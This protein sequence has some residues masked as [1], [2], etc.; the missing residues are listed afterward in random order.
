MANAGEGIDEAATAKDFL[1]VQTESNGLVGFTI[2][3]CNLDI[4]SA[5]GYHANSV[6][7]TDFRR[8]VIIFLG[9]SLCGY[10]VD[11]IAWETAYFWLMIL[12]RIGKL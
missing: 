4:I 10:T 3:Y 7:A 1:A 2:T 5:V 8:W 12:W 9:F 6:K 11:K